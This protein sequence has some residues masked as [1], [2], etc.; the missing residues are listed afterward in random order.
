LGDEGA[1]E[2]IDRNDE[3]DVYQLQ[4]VK[5]RKE[6]IRMKSEAAADFAGRIDRS[7]KRERSPSKTRRVSK[8]ITDGDGRRMLLLEL[9]MP[10]SRL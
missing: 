10:I 9:P 3:V 1:I 2:W 5:E 4:L 6:K 8:A 7:V